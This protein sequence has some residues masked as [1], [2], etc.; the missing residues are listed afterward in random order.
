MGVAAARARWWWWLWLPLRAATAS[1]GEDASADEDVLAIL[2][3]WTPCN[4]G[5][6]GFEV[7]PMSG[8]SYYHEC[9]EG[10]GTLKMCG[11]PLVFNMAMEYCDFP[12]QV[13]CPSEGIVCPE[14][15]G[16][17]TRAPVGP[18]YSARP[19]RR[20]TQKPTGPP[21]SEPTRAPSPKTPAPTPAPTSR[22]TA[23]PTKIPTT[24]APTPAPMERTFFPTESPT[25]ISTT[26]MPTLDPVSPTTSPSTGP[27]TSQPISQPTSQPTTDAPTLPVGSA[28]YHIEN[29][30][31]RME[32]LVLVSRPASG[33]A[34]P[35]RTYTYD[36]FLQSLQIMGVL[37]FGADFQFL[38]W[39]GDVDKYHYGLVNVAAFLANAMVEAIENGKSQS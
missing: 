10:R 21:T 16:G 3:C 25:M 12:S 15:L 7:L 4:F 24:T 1:D 34:A 5:F 19:T 35:S 8:C 14:N 29:C 9:W 28:I 31:E 38:L 37:G 22:P 11:P 33:P 20:P 6:T 2:R 39:E 30:R 18:I 13:N 23:A 17:T 26:P 32:Q 36:K 27:P